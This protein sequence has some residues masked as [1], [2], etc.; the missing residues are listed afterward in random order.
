[1]LHRGDVMVLGCLTSTLTAQ[2]ATGYD[3]A[4]VAD[5]LWQTLKPLSTI[6]VRDIIKYRTKKETR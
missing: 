3:L 4:S 6:I 2:T 1:M 5:E